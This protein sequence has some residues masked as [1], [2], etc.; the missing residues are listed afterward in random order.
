MLDT[1]LQKENVL[2]M[3][4]AQTVSGSAMVI[5]MQDF[6]PELISIISF[7]NDTSVVCLILM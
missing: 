3:R 7:G 2:L 6:L 5:Y 4:I 1:S